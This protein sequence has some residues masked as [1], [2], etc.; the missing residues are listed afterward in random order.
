MLISEDYGRCIFRGDRVG[1][2]ALLACGQVR[3]SWRV[4]ATGLSARGEEGSIGQAQLCPE[5]G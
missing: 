4:L 5:R 2:E 3:Q 1:D